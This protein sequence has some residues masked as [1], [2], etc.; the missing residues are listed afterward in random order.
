MKSCLY[1]IGACLTLA[2]TACERDCVNMEARIKL[3]GFTPVELSQIQLKSYSKGVG[4]TNAVDSVLLDAAT[5]NCYLSNDTLE[6]SPFINNRPGLRSTHD[7]LVVIT[8]TGNRF[9]IT[10]VTENY[11]KNQRPFTSKVACMNTLSSY[12]VNGVVFAS[13]G[14][15]STVYLTR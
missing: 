13:D 1:I 8:A 7:Y 5:C 15:S 11:L 6:V 10:A 2:C 12:T 4:F 14:N 3:V 9:Q